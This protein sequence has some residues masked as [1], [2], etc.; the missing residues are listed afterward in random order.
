[1]HRYI[2]AYVKSTSLTGSRE[3]KPFTLTVLVP[4]GVRAYKGLYIFFTLS[5]NTHPSPILILNTYSIINGPPI[6]AFFETFLYV[7]Q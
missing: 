5:H 3:K 4:D 7:E 1:M 2:Y 6:L